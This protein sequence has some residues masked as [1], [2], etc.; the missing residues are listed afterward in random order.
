MYVSIWGIYDLDGQT[1]VQYTK[2]LINRRE[3]PYKNSR[4]I[5]KLIK[6]QG[7]TS[8]IALLEITRPY[9]LERERKLRPLTEKSVKSYKN[10]HKLS[11]NTRIGNVVLLR[12]LNIQV[13]RH[14]V[15]GA[16]AL[17][18]L[19]RYV[20]TGNSDSEP[21]N[22]DDEPCILFQTWVLLVCHIRLYQQLW[23]FLLG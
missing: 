23:Y 2:I 8:Q 5:Y 22:A 4:A 11:A 3:L 1:L 19:G 13:F 21:F 15:A 7:S 17:Y 20:G 10:S 14:H 18:V 12:T 16:D 9:M 6:S